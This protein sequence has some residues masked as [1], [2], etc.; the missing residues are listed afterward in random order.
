MQR[1]ADAD[2]RR[3]A[4]E[5]REPPDLRA[6]PVV[7]TKESFADVLR[8]GSRRARGMPSYQ[9]LNDAQLD[10]LRHYI[11]SRAAAKPDADSIGAGAHP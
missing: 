9:N 5:G 7:L 10:A 2:Q 8:S 4:G 3:P 1:R 11:R 6:S